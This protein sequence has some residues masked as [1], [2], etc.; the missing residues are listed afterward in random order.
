ML[1]IESDPLQQCQRTH[2]RKRKLFKA[3]WRI[4]LDALITAATKSFQKS[5]KNGFGLN[6]LLLRGFFPFSFITLFSNQ[7]APFG[8]ICWSSQLKFTEEGIK[9]IHTFFTRQQYYLSCL[10]YGIFHY[11]C[12]ICNWKI[13]ILFSKTLFWAICIFVIIHAVFCV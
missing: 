12:H 10:G 13:Y 8:K 3:L 5:K 11:P 2:L 9:L 4:V 1:V 7:L 6:H